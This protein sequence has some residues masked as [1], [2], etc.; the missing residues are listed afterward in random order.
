[1][2]EA[3][4]TTGYDAMAEIDRVLIDPAGERM[5]DLVD[6]AA[7]AESGQ[8]PAPAWADLIH[9]TKRAIA[10]GIQARRCAG[11]RAPCLTAS[12]PTASRS[13]RH[14]TRSR[15]CSR[16]SRSIGPTFPRAAVWLR[17]CGGR[18]IRRRPDLADAIAALLPL[19]ADPAL[20]R[21][22]RFQQTT[23]PVMAKG[24]EDTAFYRQTRLGTLTEVGGDPSVFA[25][26]VGGLP[27]RA[28][29][30]AGALAARDDLAVDARHEARRGRPRPSV[31]DHRARRRVARD[32]CPAACPVIDRRRAVGQPAVPGRDRRL[33]D[34]P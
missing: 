15:S 6:A 26:P 30:A 5:L 24:V 18:G 25:L 32:V 1:M 14:R 19:L 27:S 13:P 31:G 34:L 11:S 17:R 4:G 21:G 33:A 29:V 8:P 7:R 20:D 2:V 28:D 23:G 12:F 3:D 16:A 22:R 9:A 10:D